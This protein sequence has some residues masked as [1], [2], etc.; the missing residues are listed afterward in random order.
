MSCSIVREL[1][2]EWGQ[3]AG[4]MGAGEA[5]EKYLPQCPMPDAQCPKFF[6]FEF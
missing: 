6:H 1:Y 5:G 3:G 4:G 2:G